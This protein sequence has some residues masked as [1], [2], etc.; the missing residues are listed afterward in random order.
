M[1]SGSKFSC[2]LCRG[3]VKV[4]VI[5]IGMY[6][7]SR[8][9][10]CGLGFLDPPLPEGGISYEEDFYAEQGAIKDP[11]DGIRENVPRVKFVRRFK[12][13][14]DLLDVGC[15]LGFFLEAAR[16]EGF[17]VAGLE[18][19]RWATDYIQGHFGIP[20]LPAPVETVSLEDNSQDV[21]TLWQVIEHLPDPLAVLGR[22][23]GLLRSKGILV[24]ETRNSTG[25]D[26]RALGP[27]WGGWTL[28]HHLWHF[29]PRS[30][31]LLV[32]KSGFRVV[33]VKLHYSDAVKKRMRKI[34]VLSLLR[35]PV[36]S[37]FPGSNITIV[38][39]KSGSAG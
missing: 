4:P 28:P 6:A 22:I 35:N 5:A 21:C 10:A 1:G 24:M 19:S 12:K 2:Y 27:K 13:T 29:D 25:Y 32:E 8:C 39:E 7:V 36:S 26:A 30:L 20:V 16:G 9:P 11:S 3:D 37:L 23:R 15:G 18:W 14:G 34:P 17:S 31:R 38:G 33:Q